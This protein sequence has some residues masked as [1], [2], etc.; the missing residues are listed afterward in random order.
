MRCFTQ[1]AR[2]R[3]EKRKAFQLTSPLDAL[4]LHVNSGCRNE[5]L[6]NVSHAYIFRTVCKISIFEMLVDIR[7]L[8][9]KKET[10]K[11]HFVGI[12]S[13]GIIYF[14]VSILVS[15][16]GCSSAFELCRDVWM[17]CLDSLVG[18]CWLFV[19]KYKVLKHLPWFV[20]LCSVQNK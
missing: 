14:T 16:E 3:T 10:V 9:L 11:A 18:I 6:K 2:D 17:C 7:S 4:S 13:K 20:C 8:N 1:H 5:R 19:S 15:S 12:L